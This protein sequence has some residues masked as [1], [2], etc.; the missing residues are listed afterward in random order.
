MAEFELGC[1][2]LMNRTPSRNR[3]RQHLAGQPTLLM[4]WLGFCDVVNTRCR[5]EGTVCFYQVT[6]GQMVGP[7][8]ADEPPSLAFCEWMLWKVV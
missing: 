1:L 6:D 2:R 3:H 5:P 7:P 4:A 8:K